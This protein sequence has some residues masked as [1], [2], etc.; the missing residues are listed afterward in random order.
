VKDSNLLFM[1]LANLAEWEGLAV[2]VI[3]ADVPETKKFTLVIN[4][5]NNAVGCSIPRNEMLGRWRQLPLPPD[6]AMF[7]T[8]EY[9]K[10]IKRIIQATLVKTIHTLDVT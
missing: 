9:I 5:P 6:L 4:I 8:P 1:A 10:R 7:N 3:E 2:G